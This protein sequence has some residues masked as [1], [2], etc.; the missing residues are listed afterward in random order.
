MKPFCRF[1]TPALSHWVTLEYLMSA[2][3]TEKLLIEHGIS[4]EWSNRPGDPFIAKARSS[5]A[6]EFLKTD[7]TDLFFLDDDIGWPAEKVLEFINRPE[8]VIAG[9][10]PHKMEELSFPCSLEADGDHLVEENGLFRA[11]LA[12]TGFMR[13]KREVL[14]RLYDASPPYRE[15]EADGITYERRAIFN[16]GVGV[17]GNY[18]GEDYAFC[19]ACRAADIPVWIDPNINF[20]HRGTRRWAANMGDSI[21]VFKE[22]AAARAAAEQARSAA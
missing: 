1:S 17:D 18:W 12:P 3:R 9:V 20:F 8:P 11:V 10:Y 4:H 5:A 2:L 6:C 15:T 14:E 22:K 13:I 16:S 21:Q 7:G 19:N